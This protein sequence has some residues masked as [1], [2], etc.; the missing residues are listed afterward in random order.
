VVVVLVDYWWRGVV[1][2]VVVRLAITV[3]YWVGSIGG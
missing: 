2:A 1:D 3:R